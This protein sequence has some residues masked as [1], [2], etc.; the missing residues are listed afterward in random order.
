M[1]NFI[2]LF[3]ILLSSTLSAQVLNG[4]F[5]NWSELGPLANPDVAPSE[6]SSANEQFFLYT[7]LL[8]VFEV[9]GES[10]SAMRLETIEANGE[11]GASYAIWGQT[12]DDEGEDLVFGG[13]FPFADSTV[14]GIEMDLR[15]DVNPLSPAVILVQFKLNGEAILGGTSIFYVDGVQSTFQTMTFD[16]PMALPVT[17]DQCVIAFTSNNLLEDEDDQLAFAGD[18]IEI[19]NIHFVGTEETIPGGDLDTWIEGDP[20]LILDDWQAFTPPG[21]GV[22]LQSEDSFEGDYALNLNNFEGDSSIVQSG[23]V[24]LGEVGDDEL[25]AS[26]P[27]PDDVISLNFQ[28]KYEGVDGDSAL[29]FLILSEDIEN[30]EEG[31]YYSTQ[32]IGNTAEYTQGSIDFEFVY[33]FLSPEYYSIVI[34]STKIFDFEAEAH[35]GTSLWID[36]FEWELDPF[37]CEYEPT[38]EQGDL[39][40]CPDEIITINTQEYDNYQWYSQNVFFGDPVLLEGDTLQTLDIDAFNF[41]VNNVWCVVTLDG[42]TEATDPVYIDGYAFIPPAISSDGLSDICEGDSTLLENAFG[43]Y[44]T[45]QWEDDGV[46]IEGA[47]DS[48]LWVTESGNYTLSVTPMECP[49]FVMNNGIAVSISVHDIP[50]PVIELDGTSLMTTESFTEYQWY[51]NGSE[52]SGAD[53]ESYELSEDGEYFVVVSDQW[54][55]EGTSDTF[56]YT[57]IDSFTKEALSIYPNPAKDDLWLEVPP[58]LNSNSKMVLFDLLGNEIISRTITKSNTHLNIEDLSS[59][60]YFVRITSENQE[61]TVKLIVNN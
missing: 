52:I 22:V 4:G 17:P 33:D 45:Y 3:T 44:E 28:Y 13:G 53:D 38:V 26:I 50:M 23:M 51:M 36:A 54:G 42:C 12:P 5:E 46:E 29:V 57:G 7:G 2:L 31:M 48:Q 58:A 40:L 25:L 9:P 16:F 61:W 35:L 49:S 30:T 34:V 41:A 18:F 59:G 37:A 20:I 39:I 47:D 55:C 32:L 56:S 19:D 21:M 24:F 1:R 27:L 14:T 8:S 11:A 60:A 10:G 6:F 43:M 15:Y